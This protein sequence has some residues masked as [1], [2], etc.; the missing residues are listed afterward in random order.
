MAKGRKRGKKIFWCGLG[1]FV[2]VFVGTFFGV[3]YFTKTGVFRIPGVV[4]Y[5][6]SLN[7]DE[8]AVLAEILTDEIDVY[9]D[10]TRSARNELALP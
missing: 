5:D 7:D 10:F 8:L 1:I 2:L 4:Y 6:E 9:K 3:Q